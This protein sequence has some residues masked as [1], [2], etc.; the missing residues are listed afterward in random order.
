METPII[1][2]V[3]E[4]RMPERLKTLAEGGRTP[5][6]WVWYFGRINIIKSFIRAERI[7]DHAGHLSC[8]ISMLNTFAAAGHHQYAKGAR[9]YVQL[10]QQR[11]ESPA[12]QET[13]TKFTVYGNHAVRFSDHEWS[14]TWTDIAIETTLMR[15]A[16]SSGGLNRGRFRNESSHKSWVQTLNHFS[17]IQ[18][19]LEGQIKCGVPVHGDLTRAQMEKDNNSVQAMVG[20]LEEVNPFDNTRDKKTLVSFSTGFSSSSGDP[21]N[22]DQAEEIGRNIQAKM[23]GKT[24]LDTMQTKYKVKSLATLRSGPKVNGERLVL[25]SLRFFNRLIIICEREVKTK[26]ALHFELTPIPMSLFDK[27]QKMR[28][29]DKAAL[30]KFLKAYVEPVE[31]PPCASLVIDGGWLL[32]NVKWEAN[33]TWRNIAESYLR[34]VKAM[35]NKHIQITVVF[36]GYGHSTKDHDHLRRTKHACCDIQ[37]RPDIHNIIPREKF[38][39]NQ[40]NKAQLISLLAKTFSDNGIQVLQCSDDADISIVQLAL[41]EARE[42]AVEVRAEDTD[43][44]VMLIHHITD[45]SIFITTA[46]NVSYNLAKLKEALPEKYRKYLLFLHSFS[47]CDTVSAI[48]GFSK[49]TLLQKLCKTNGAEKA[50]DVFLD[51]HAQKDAIITAGCEMFNLIFQGKSSKKL[52]DLRFEMFSKRAAAG[53][54]RPEKLPPTTATAAQHSL[55]AYL[56]NR[57]WLMLKS[58]SLDVLKYGWKLEKDVYTPVPTTDPIA[59]KYLL[60][61]ISCNCEGDCSTRRCS[62]KRQGVKCISA[63]GKCNGECTNV[64]QPDEEET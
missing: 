6:L 21:V 43:I 2:T 31:Q 58:P 47:G 7:A 42:S 34:F 26:E 59:P 17:F 38:L 60:E 39:D 16:K 4:E 40:S 55:R 25:D 54:I 11:Q 27:N 9:L 63:C 29:P 51:L 61:F 62:C 19:K 35:G 23:D 52:E 22:A 56:Q 41:D 20:W 28:K 18:Q 3:F 57:D 13:L 37:I 49:P 32:H 24:A 12:F 30:A 44:L 36:D 14:G 50:M 33:L 64:S 46:K 1:V 45:Q 8:I 53:N 10:M 5:A 48:S 15:E